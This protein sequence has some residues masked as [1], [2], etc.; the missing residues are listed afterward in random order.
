[1]HVID[2]SAIDVILE[3]GFC[4]MKRHSILVAV[5]AGFL[6]VSVAPAH[7]F[8]SGLFPDFDEDGVVGFADFLQFA[9]KFGAELGDETYEDRFDLDGDGLIGFPDF[10]VFA[11]SFGRVSLYAGD[12]NDVN[13]RDVN[14]R[15]VIADSLGK[16]R[17][18]PITRAEMATLTELE[19]PDAE[20]SDLTGLHLLR[21]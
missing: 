6:W 8:Q 4:Y 9:G 12:E 1:M 17:D 15:A 18:A 14:L 2:T 21:I 5:V 10:L 13:I 19:A 16:R 11:G 20:I 7:A 3:L